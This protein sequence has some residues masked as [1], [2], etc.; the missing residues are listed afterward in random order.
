MTSSTIVRAVLAAL[1]FFSLM[2][3]AL[4]T[5]LN[6]NEDLDACVR[7]V[8]AETATFIEECGNS[9]PQSKTDLDFAFRNWSVLKLSIPAIEEALDAKSQL[10]TTLSKAV[11][12]YLKRIP[13]HE[14]EIECV[15]RLNMVRNPEPKLQG[16]SAPLPPNALSKYA[17]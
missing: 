5:A 8:I 2:P 9:Y 3:H 7:M 14:R 4:A 13:S 12:P 6:C 16:D 15:G 1:S 11:A 17:K 10:R